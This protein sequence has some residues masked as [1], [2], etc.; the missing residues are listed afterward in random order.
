MCCMRIEALL[1]TPEYFSRRLR[2]TSRNCHHPS[3]KSWRKV[4][5]SETKIPDQGGILGWFAYSPNSLIMRHEC[6]K[7]P[8][9]RTALLEATV[10]KSVGSSGQI[11]LGKEYAGRK[12]LIEKPAEGVWIIRTVTV[13]PD[14]EL[15]LHK[16]ENQEGLGRA[17]EWA[18]K[19]P[20]R[21]SDPDN[22]T[23]AR[24]RAGIKKTRPT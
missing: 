4:T 2:I 5:R 17:L 20:A 7:G 19:T 13:I 22:L 15:W 12:V 21:S 16:K 18:K 24:T 23:P 8:V 3:D 10:I 14:N 1:T 9:M 11:S 6:M